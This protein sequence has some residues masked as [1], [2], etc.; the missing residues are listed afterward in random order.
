VRAEVGGDA[1]L[2]EF[3]GVVERWN[4]VRLDGGS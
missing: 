3:V 2:M 4:D 1:D